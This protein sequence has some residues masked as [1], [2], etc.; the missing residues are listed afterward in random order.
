MLPLLLMILLNVS[1]FAGQKTKKLDV[2]F[3]WP[4]RHAKKAD[5]PAAE[6]RGYHQASPHE[7][8]HL[9]AAGGA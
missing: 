9:E 5:Y 3:S 2:D 6:D 7:E 4:G 1:A 8:E